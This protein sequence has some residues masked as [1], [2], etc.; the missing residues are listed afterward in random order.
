MRALIIEDEQI[1]ARELCDTIK[2]VSPNIEIAAI[3]PS[4]KASR[5]WFAE[6]QEPDLIFMDIQLSDGVSFELFKHIRIN[7]PVIFTTAYNEYAIQAI[8][9]NALDYLLKPVDRDELA[10]ALS[11]IR[12]K[13]PV[14]INDN[15]EKL[16]ELF[17][18]NRPAGQVAI[19]T[20]EGLVM[21]KT[22][23][24]IYCESNSA[25]TSFILADKSS[26]LCSKNLKEVEDVLSGKNFYR[27]HHS[28]LININYIKKYVKGNGGEVVMANDS[29]IPISR[30]K[31]QEFLNMLERV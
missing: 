11:R 8:R 4:I 6:N 19:P 29:H 24:I 23:D 3:L 17:S 13:Q 26:I 15:I 2:D 10:M 9:H 12:A 27:I 22:N 14:V 18:A 20:M 16:L 30:K 31:K 25:Y 7:C 21:I 1:I 5:K 28:Y